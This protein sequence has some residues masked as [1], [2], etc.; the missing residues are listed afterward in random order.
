MNLDR[1]H[2]AQDSAGDGF[3]DALRELRAGRKTSHWI[4]AISGG[5][6]TSEAC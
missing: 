6:A 3:A 5:V 4:W 1:F 2:Q